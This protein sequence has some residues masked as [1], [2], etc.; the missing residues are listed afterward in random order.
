MD[1]ANLNNQN[2]EEL[3][4]LQQKLGL[5]NEELLE[6]I[7][8]QKEK[9]KKKHNSAITAAACCRSAVDHA[10]LHTITNKPSDFAHS[11]TNISYNN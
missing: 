6:N 2:D 11:G 8:I 7:R 10:K 1:T 4:A 3:S 5:S 9:N